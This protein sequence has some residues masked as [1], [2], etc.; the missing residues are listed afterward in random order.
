[1]H[2]SEAYLGRA[3]EAGT[4]DCADLVRD[5]ARDRLGI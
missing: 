4:Y 1:M 5:V 3:W 2:W